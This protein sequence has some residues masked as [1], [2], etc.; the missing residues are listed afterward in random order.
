MDKAVHAPM[1]MM[2]KKVV[3]DIAK[4]IDHTYYGASIENVFYS[5]AVIDDTD[6]VSTIIIEGANGS[7]YVAQETNMHEY[8]MLGWVMH[9]F[10]KFLREEAL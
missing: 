3:R 2:H 7:H 1:E 6:I 8:E 4:A 9:Q 5:E 10:L